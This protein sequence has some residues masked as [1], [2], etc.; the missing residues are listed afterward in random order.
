[1]FQLPLYEESPEKLSSLRWHMYSAD[2]T[3]IFI[4]YG[5][6]EDVR[7]SAEALGYI[8]V[9]ESGYY[10][11][12]TNSIYNAKDGPVTYEENRRSF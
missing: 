4:M 12:T 2:R 5:K 8:D 6:E 7:A 11:Y 10:S 9:Q 3:R 1:M